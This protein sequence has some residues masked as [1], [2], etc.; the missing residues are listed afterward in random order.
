ME[1]NNITELSE[2]KNRMKVLEDKILKP[3]LSD[4]NHIA[5]LYEW[6]KNITSEIEDFYK[7]GSTEYKQVLLF[8]I[9]V[10]YCPRALSDDFLTRGL[11]QRLA[12]MLN[13][14][15]SHTSNLIKN[16]SFYY[17]KYTQFRNNCDI[18]LAEIQFRIEK[19]I[20]ELIQR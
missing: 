10:L 14:S 16:I 19:R 18:V 2:L 11:R 7:E 5:L 12:I 20:L 15:P 9:L 1:I 13:I 8:C 17:Q 3:Q 4:L 6:Y